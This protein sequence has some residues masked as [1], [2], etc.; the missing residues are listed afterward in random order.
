MGDNNHEVD[1]MDADGLPYYY[2]GIMLETEYQNMYDINNVNHEYSYFINCVNGNIHNGGST[3]EINMD[4]AP[5]SL[6]YILYDRENGTVEWIVNGVP[7][8]R[9]KVFDEKLKKGKYH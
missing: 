5:G 8:E 2:I 3:T 4:I 6:I 9:M 7:N 1:F